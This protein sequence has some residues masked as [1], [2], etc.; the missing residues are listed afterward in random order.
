MRAALLACLCLMSARVSP[1][2]AEGTAP[3]PLPPHPRLLATPADFKR[4]RDSVTQPGPLH[5]AF[6]LLRETAEREYDAP[7]VRREVVGR[8]MLAVSRDAVR[9]VWNGALLYRLTGEPRWAARTEREMLALA[10]FTDWNPSHFLDTAEAA[11]ALAVGYDWLYEALPPS[12]RRVLR[13]ALVRHALQPG[14]SDRL[15]WRTR[16]NNWRQVCEAGLTLAAL[17]IG[18]DEPELAARAVERARRNLPAIFQNYAPDGSYVEGPMY[19][20]YGTTYHLLLVEA[21]RTATGSSGNLAA[22]PSFLQSAAVV[23]LLTA[24]SGD[25]FNFGDCT[26]R[27]LFMPAM[28]WFARE[29]NRPDL[30]ATEPARLR[31]LPRDNRVRSGNTPFP[32]RFLALALLW[33]PAGPAPAPAAPPASWFGQ[34]PNPLAVFRRG[35]GPASLYAAIKG[36]RGRLSHAH[37]DAGSFLLEAGGVR[38]TADLGMPDYHQLESAGVDLFGQDRWNV[39]ALGPHSHSIPLLDDSAPDENATATLSAFSSQ[40]P[41]AVF[42]LTPLYAAQVKRLHRGLRIESDTTVIL[43]DEIEG[44]PEGTRY[45]FSWMTRAAVTV[46]PDGVDLRKNGKKLRITFLSDA[47]LEIRDEDAAVPPAPYDAPQPGLRR[48]SVLFTVRKPAHFLQVRATL[49]DAPAASAPGPALSAW[50]YDMR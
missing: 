28:Y 24:P 20:E 25:F 37:M 29:T 10:A 15:W 2:A 33:M 18:E 44:A 13:E 7:P 38:W 47:S 23:N 41:C 45:R 12:S 32:G 22:N 42:D 17:S 8:R 9:R 3:A 30:V 4:I 35:E 1:G 43:R 26:P 21:L 14:D 11:A 49:D 19:W 6:D 36:G 50:L 48:V 34:G 39:Y 31:E 5:E 46:G 40:P 27:R 16:V